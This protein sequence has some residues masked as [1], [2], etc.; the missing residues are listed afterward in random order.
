[1]DSMP[2]VGRAEFKIAGAFKEFGADL[3]EK[4]VLDIGSS[5]GGFTEFALRMGVKRVIAVEKAQ[6]R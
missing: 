6:T 2:V 3:R 4:V 1:M 5:T